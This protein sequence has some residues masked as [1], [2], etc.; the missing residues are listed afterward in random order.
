MV[1][2]T[3]GS[4]PLY[5][6]DDAVD[7]SL[8]AST[9]SHALPL[10]RLAALGH[11]AELGVEFTVM[12]ACVSFPTLAV[13]AVAHHYTFRGDGVVSHRGPGGDSELTVDPQFFVVDFPGWS[14]RVD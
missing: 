3:G 8:D 2:S 12:V 9:F 5:A 4:N 6:L 11:D 13:R 1:E 14:A 7:I 10:R